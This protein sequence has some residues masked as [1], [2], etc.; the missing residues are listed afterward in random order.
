M[1]IS[2]YVLIKKNHWIINYW[3]VSDVPMSH[4]ASKL[5]LIQTSISV[6]SHGASKLN[7]CR[8]ETN[9]NVNF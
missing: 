3:K 4:G 9:S 1:S 2:N 5:R 6:M 7:Q 8:A